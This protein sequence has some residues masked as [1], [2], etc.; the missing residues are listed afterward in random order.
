MTRSC[1]K[2]EKGMVLPV[3][4][5]R[6]PAISPRRRRTISAALKNSRAF[7]AGGVPAQAGKASLAAAMATL[8]SSGPQFGTRAKRLPV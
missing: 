1:W 4:R 6:I 7:S 2:V 8:A 5:A 3:S